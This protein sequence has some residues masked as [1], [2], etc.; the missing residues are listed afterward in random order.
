MYY[1]VVRDVGLLGDERGANVSLKNVA[2]LLSIGYNY[3]IVAST[4]Y[5]KQKVQH[6]RKWCLV[7]RRN[8]LFHMN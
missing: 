7:M 1:L 4:L 3:T 5:F 6:G 8:T 2:I